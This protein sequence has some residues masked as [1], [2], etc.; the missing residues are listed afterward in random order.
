MG[1]SFDMPFVKEYCNFSGAK[2]GRYIRL[3]SVLAKRTEYTWW[4]RRDRPVGAHIHLDSRHTTPAP[5][6]NSGPP[7]RGPR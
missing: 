4:K 2:S 7:K 6:T 5:S 1:V 3:P